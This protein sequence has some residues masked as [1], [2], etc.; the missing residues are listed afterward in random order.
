MKYRILTTVAASC[1]AGSAFAGAY[2]PAPAD[3][4][5]VAPAPAP[6][7]R[8]TP[9]WTGFY[10]GAQAGYGFGDAEAG[11]VE[12]DFDGFLGGVHAGYN[13]DFGQFVL[14]GEIDYNFAELEFDDAPDVKIDQVARIKLKA[15]YDTG[16]A[17]VYGAAG[18]AYAN[19]DNGLGDDFN[20]WGWAVGAGVDVMVRR[21]ISAGIE[22]MYH[23][24]DDFDDQGVDV[25]ANTLTARVSYHF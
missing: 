5:V 17:L 20:D 12:E 7:A 1:I 18:A 2:E 15:G 4:V 9:D 24:F 3:T 13:H 21:N 6:V 25:N 22:Y 8:V 16:R 23:Q 19:L 10:L 14:G 11:G